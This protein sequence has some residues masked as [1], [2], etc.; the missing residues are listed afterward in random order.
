MEA[1]D[2]YQDRCYDLK[3][4]VIGKIQKLLGDKTISLEKYNYHVIVVERHCGEV[5]TTSLECVS[6][7]GFTDEDGFCQ[8]SQ[9]IT[10][11]LCFILDKLNELL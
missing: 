8:W 1:K 5:F 3:H 4:E 6:Y 7:D 10:D 2:K 11:D 9:M